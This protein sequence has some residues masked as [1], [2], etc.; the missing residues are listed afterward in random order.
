LAWRRC[1]LDLELRPES[2]KEG[3]VGLDQTSRWLRA[4]LGIQVFTQ[5]CD[6][7]DVSLE[8]KQVFYRV[9]QEA[10]QNIFKHA[11]ASQVNLKLDMDEGILR[12]SIQDNGRGFDVEGEYSGHMGLMSMRERVEKIGVLKMHIPTRKLSSVETTKVPLKI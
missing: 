10:L 4:R 5:C 8:V 1:V 6:E 11:Q 7:P 12:M 2:W 9:A 3:P